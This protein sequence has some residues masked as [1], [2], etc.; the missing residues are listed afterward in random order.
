MDDEKK[1]PGCL[2]KIIGF[3]IVIVVAAFIIRG[4]NSNSQT[5]KTS[6][7]PEPAPITYDVNID[8]LY[9]EKLLSSN[10]ICDIYIDNEKVA[11]AQAADTI[12]SISI[13]LEEGKHSIRIK[14]ADWGLTTGTQSNS[15]D[16]IVPSN[17]G[18]RFTYKKTLA[19]IELW[20]ATTNVV[21][22]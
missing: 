18:Y 12:K 5:I 8:V 15:V 1:E 20:D 3:I 13:K 14:T 6:P 22:N 21:V 4:C 16:F 9:E 2:S 17:S 10:P 11:E 7:T 19:S